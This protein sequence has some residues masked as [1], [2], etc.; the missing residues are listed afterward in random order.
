MIT[1]KLAKD[2]MAQTNIRNT[3][4][5]SIP[6]AACDVDT[7]CKPLEVVSTIDDSEVVVTISV[8][9]LDEN[10]AGKVS[11]PAIVAQWSCATDFF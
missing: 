10:V 11:N 6:A 9:L 1:V 2:P 8:V 5:G 3:F 7:V 4:N